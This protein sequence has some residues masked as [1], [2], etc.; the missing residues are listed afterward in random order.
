M[1]RRLSGVD[2]IYY[3][4][5]RRLG[6]D[7]VVAPGARAGVCIAIALP[8]PARRR[9]CRWQPRDRDAA[10]ALHQ[11]APV[12]YQ[13]INGARQPVGGGFVIATGRVSSASADT[14]GVC[15]SSSTRC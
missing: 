13:D 5:Q 7:F 10:A 9:R 8:A 14:I 15:R 2:L 1:P 12:L 3:R 11:P 6:Y 4:N